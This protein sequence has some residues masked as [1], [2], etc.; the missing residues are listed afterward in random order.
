M[1]SAISASSSSSIICFHQGRQKTFTEK[2]CLLKFFC[3]IHF[4]HAL[5]LSLLLSIEICVRVCEFQGFGRCFLFPVSYCTLP[6]ATGPVQNRSSKKLTFPIKA[7]ENDWA[8]TTVGAHDHV[9]AKSGRKHHHGGALPLQ[10]SVRRKLEW[11][12]FYPI[13]EKGKKRLKETERKEINIAH[14]GDDSSIGIGIK[15]HSR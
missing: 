5:S 12:V 6:L 3:C 13:R 10:N 2:I 1:P 14:G 4:S 15:I 7:G 9:L 11:N 8:R